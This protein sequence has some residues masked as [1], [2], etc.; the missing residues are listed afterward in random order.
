MTY[1]EALT[2]DV[3]AYSGLLEE[4][5]GYTC[6]VGTDDE[7]ELCYWLV[8]LC[9]DDEGDPWYE[10]QD[11]VGDTVDTVVERLALVEA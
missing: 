8:D 3:R 5:T 9:G 4:A 11:L 1:E 10:W 7:G 6:R 2:M